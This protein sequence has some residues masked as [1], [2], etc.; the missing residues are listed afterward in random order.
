M[1]DELRVDEWTPDK[2]L[3]ADATRQQIF[4]R[5][6]HLHREAKTLGDATAPYYAVAMVDEVQKAF[7]ALPA[8][9]A[10][11]A[12]EKCHYCER[13]AVLV[14]ER[15]TMQWGGAR[16]GER[17]FFHEADAEYWRCEKCGEEWYTV[18]QSRK[19]DSQCL[20]AIT[21]AWR[22][23]ATAPVPPITGA[24]YTCRE[25]H[26]DIAEH[27]YASG[28]CDARGCQCEQTWADIYR[29]ECERL[30]A[31]LARVTPPIREDV[32]AAMDAL[33]DAA[34]ARH[35]ARRAAGDN[36]HDWQVV[37]AVKR[38][39]A[40]RTALLS[41]FP[42]GGTVGETAGIRAFARFGRA[43]MDAHW[44]NDSSGIDGDVV[45][46]LAVETGVL[47]EVAVSEPCGETCACAEW[48]F[49]MT[50]FRYTDAATAALPSLS[51]GPKDG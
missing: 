18:E 1:P 29:G 26:H 41:L 34:V 27:Q 25:C 23:L 9:T 37:E 42:S 24:D 21:K 40:A 36:W 28:V 38:V 14:K 50:C 19:L 49:P 35:C 4:D 16:E 2:P 6:S 7:A 13:E 45:Q 12:V 17:P 48:G 31:L 30:A 5:M 32:D 39:E 11:E 33:D 3:R 43:V 47:H 46:D 8:P 22:E 51:G 20:H 44:G 15:R 10:G